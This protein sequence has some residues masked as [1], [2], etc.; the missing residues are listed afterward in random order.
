MLHTPSGRQLLVLLG[1]LIARRR[2]GQGVDA[3]SCWRVVSLAG[4]IEIA[5]LVGHLL[6]V[7]HGPTASGHGPLYT[8]LFQLAWLLTAFG[9]RVGTV[10]SVTQ[11]AV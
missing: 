8:S 5:F 4:L 9:G 11:W 3:G 2:A 1:W 10:G 7:Q 6:C